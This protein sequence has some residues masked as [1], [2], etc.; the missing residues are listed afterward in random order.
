MQLKPEEALAEFWN[1]GVVPVPAPVPTLYSNITVRW[2]SIITIEL[3][4]QILGDVNNAELI[5][6]TSFLELLTPNQQRKCHT[7]ITCHTLIT[8]MSL[9]QT[10]FSL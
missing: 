5:G 2:V 3:P 10:I 8:Y 1:A 6:C 7:E 4:G 9:F